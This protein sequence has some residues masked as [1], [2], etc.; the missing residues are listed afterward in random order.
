VDGGTKL[1][2]LLLLF[3]TKMWYKEPHDRQLF[4]NS[5]GGIL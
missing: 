2:K 4:Q 5:S 3:Y 1:V